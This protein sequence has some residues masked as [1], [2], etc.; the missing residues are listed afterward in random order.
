MWVKKKPK[1]KPKPH[2]MDRINASAQSDIM[3]DIIKTAEKYFKR[4]YLICG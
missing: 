1:P 2:I 3:D 4:H